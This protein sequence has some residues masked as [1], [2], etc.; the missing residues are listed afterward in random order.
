MDCPIILS[1][2]KLKKQVKLAQLVFSDSV[3]QIQVTLHILFMFSELKFL[4]QSKNLLKFPTVLLHLLLSHL[5]LSVW[6]RCVP[7]VTPPQWQQQ[8]WWRIS[9][10]WTSLKQR[11]GTLAASRGPGRNPPTLLSFPAT[12]LLL[13]RGRRHHKLDNKMLKTFITHQP[14][15]VQDCEERPILH[16]VY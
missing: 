8:K 11:R 12:A 10:T 15:R 1:L 14:L 16:V 6:P 4:G 7:A 9:R 2:L 3:I 5:N 13:A